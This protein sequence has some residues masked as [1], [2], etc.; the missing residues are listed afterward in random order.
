[1][2]TKFVLIITHGKFGK[3]ILQSARLIMGEQKNVATLGL[4]LG[5]D[6]ESLGNEAERIIIENQKADKDTIVLVDVL[7]G[8]PS[9]V[10]LYMLKKYDIKVITGVNLSMLLELFS[11]RDSEDLDEL[12]GKVIESG[13]EGIKKFEGKK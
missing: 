2:R 3:E 5:D 9:N 13:V 7:G 1:L 4:N 11:S 8:S 10:A 12:V 6:V